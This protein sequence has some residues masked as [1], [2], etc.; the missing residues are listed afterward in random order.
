M[1]LHPTEDVDP[2]FSPSKPYTSRLYR[3][4]LRVGKCGD[5]GTGLSLAAAGAGGAGALARCGCLDWR[6]GAGVRGGGV[7]WLNFTFPPLQSQHKSI[8]LQKT[9]VNPHLG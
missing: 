4:F 1:A 9:N 7:A 2:G 6:T 8:A 3:G 5:E